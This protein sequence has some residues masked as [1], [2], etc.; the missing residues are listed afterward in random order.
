[1]ILLLTES[2]FLQA[3]NGVGKNVAIRIWT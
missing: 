3:E 2:C 1:M